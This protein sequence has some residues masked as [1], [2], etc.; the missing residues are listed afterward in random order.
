MSVGRGS[1]H[2]PLSIDVILCMSSFL[3]PISSSGLNSMVFVITTSM[4]Y[5]RLQLGLLL[6]VAR[7][8]I[9]SITGRVAVVEFN[10]CSGNQLGP[11]TLVGGKYLEI[12]TYSSRSHKK[13]FIYLDVLHI[14][15]F[16]LKRGQIDNFNLQT[17]HL[18]GGS[19]L[20]AAWMLFLSTTPW[21]R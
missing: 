9:V 15:L 14:V 7:G 11:I 21:F 16:K 6:R 13:L 18:R 10:G 5:F 8:N 19:H 4:A 20:P 3:L 1:K 12:Q 17:D 2:L